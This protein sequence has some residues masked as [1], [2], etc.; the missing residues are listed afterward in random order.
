MLTKIRTIGIEKKIPEDILRVARRI[1]RWVMK[2][3][4]GKSE[5]LCG[6][7]SAYLCRDIP[8]S[9][10]FEGTVFGE[11][12]CWVEIKNTVLDVTADQFNGIE[13]WPWKDISSPA[14]FRSIVWV[15]WYRVRGI[16]VPI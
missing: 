8:G 12:H 2:E 9:D 3:G 4:W 5:G 6:D 16:Y 7:A 11:S 15:P 14:R 10:F 1:R 13:K